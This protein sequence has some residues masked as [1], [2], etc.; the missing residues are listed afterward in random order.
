MRAAVESIEQLPTIPKL[1]M[2][3]IE[4]ASRPEISMEELSDVIHQDPSLAARILK[5]ANSSYY[6]APRQIDSLKPALVMLGLNEVQNIALGIT[7]FDV[8][9][10]L[11]P[12]LSHYREL[13]WHHCAACGFVA[14]I[15]SQ[16]LNL[17]N[18]GKDFIAGLL[19][20]IGKIVI[21]A[22]FSNEFAHVFTET[23]KHNPPMR[24][25]EHEILGESHEQ[26]GVFLAEKWHLPQA[27]CD[28]ISYHHTF[29][30][31]ASSATI[32]D[33]Q[34]V[35]VSYLSEALCEHFEIGWDG[36]FECS[37]IRNGTAWD[38]LLS[39]QDAHSSGDIDAIITETLERFKEAEP[40][41]LRIWNR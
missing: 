25:A 32:E 18:K 31:F 9:K 28:A 8:M 24:E 23:F 7:F 22:C 29:P 13:F 21:D 6:G 20:D 36:D 2:E 4:L 1:G 17:Q 15:L 10:R 16:K 26:F 37:N 34:I 27:I 11:E 14:R 19:H 3:I 38:V 41:L 39:G 30:S 40:H 12:K 5:V 33:M 35:A